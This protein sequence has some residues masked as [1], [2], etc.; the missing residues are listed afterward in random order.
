MIAAYYL[1]AMWCTFISGAFV[2]HLVTPQVI[3]DTKTYRI[4]IDYING[5]T[6]SMCEE[7]K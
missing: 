3:D 7:T 1:V 4:G 6:T 5:A 2:H